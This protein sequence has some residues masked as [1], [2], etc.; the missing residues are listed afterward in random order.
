VLHYSK[1]GFA[2]EENDLLLSLPVAF[3]VEFA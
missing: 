2:G 3:T 1:G